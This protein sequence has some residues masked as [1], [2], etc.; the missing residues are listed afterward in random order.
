MIEVPVPSNEQE[1]LASLRKLNVIDTPIEERFE[2][3]TRMA[4]RTLGVPIA[5]FTLIDDKRQWFKSIQGLNST[6]TAKELSFCA[7]VVAGN[8]ILLIPDATQDQ[9]FSDHPSVTGNPNIGFYAGCPVRSP[10][11]QTIGALC[12]IDNRPRQMDPEQLQALR[13][14]AT[15]VENEMR[16]SEISLAQDNLIA[17]LDAAH[18][19][20][21]IDPM[22]RI[23]NRNGIAEILK[24]EWAEGTRRKSPLTLVMADIDHFKKVNDT[25]GHPVGDEV[26]QAIAKKLLSTLRIED[27][28]GRMGGEE[29]LIVMPACDPAQVKSTVERIREGI[30]SE[31]IQTAAGPLEITVSYGAAI[32]MPDP[33]HT[34]DDVIKKADDA[35]YVAKKSGR[36]RVEISQA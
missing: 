5:A 35:L 3:L 7:H 4:C 16:L 24:R 6:E 29:F 13:D 10:D 32:T 21:L 17:E 20:A 8:D 19:L 1:R 28:I 15:L 25:H 22:T 33:N 34:A 12:A 9:R 23:W 36:N 26:I 27:A 18:R 30:L 11:G 2:R 14:L 31:P